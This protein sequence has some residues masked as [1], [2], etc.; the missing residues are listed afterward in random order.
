MAE[1]PLVYV[2]A[3][4]FISSLGK[5]F[6]KM[7]VGAIVVNNKYTIATYSCEEKLKSC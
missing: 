7:P 1:M 5:R 6:F 2:K 4:Q 3:F